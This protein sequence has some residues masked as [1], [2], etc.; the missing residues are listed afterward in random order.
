MCIVVDFKA[1]QAI[2]NQDEYK[3]KINAMD[4]VELLEEMVRFQEE[5]ASNPTTAKLITQG[6][7]LFD[8]IYNA[9]E[10][11]ELKSLSRA[12]TITLK[13]EAPRY[14]IKFGV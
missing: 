7:I 3:A 10:T 14:G 12:I 6:V 1:Y 9:A 13:L 5:R 8:R 2:K 4:K 11:Q